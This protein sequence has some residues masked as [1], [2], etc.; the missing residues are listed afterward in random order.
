MVTIIFGIVI[1]MGYEI[2]L[3]YPLSDPLKLYETVHARYKC[4]SG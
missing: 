3:P 2:N 1:I 4:I